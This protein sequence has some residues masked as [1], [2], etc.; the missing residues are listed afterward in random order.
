MSQ[1]PCK[2]TP[3]STILPWNDA[4]DEK[5][6]A[7]WISARNEERLKEAKAFAEHDKKMADQGITVIR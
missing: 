4:W 3:L 1:S 5:T 6:K 2:E 7:A